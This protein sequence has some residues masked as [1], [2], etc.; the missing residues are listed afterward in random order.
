MSIGTPILIEAHG[1]LIPLSIGTPILIEAHGEL[2]PLSPLKMFN[3]TF[4]V[5][6]PNWCTVFVNSPKRLLGKERRLLVS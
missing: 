3:N 1:E 2:I 5:K 6:I 4:V